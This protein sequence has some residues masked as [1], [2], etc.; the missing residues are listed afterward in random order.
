MNDWCT[1][2][3]PIPPTP[4][5]AVTILLGFLHSFV[6]SEL[7][8]PKTAANCAA[9][10]PLVFK[11]STDFTSFK[12]PMAGPG[13]GERLQPLCLCIQPGYAVTMSPIPSLTGG[14]HEGKVG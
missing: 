8:E 12:K 2:L 11:A 1:T 10:L 9:A 14:S 3:F 6:V 4:K 7:L 5:H 13:R